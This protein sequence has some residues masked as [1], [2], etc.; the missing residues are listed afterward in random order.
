VGPEVELHDFPGGTM[1]WL[2]ETLG[3]LN[4]TAA[5]SQQQFFLMQHHPFHNRDSLDPFGHNVLFNFT[6]DDQQDKR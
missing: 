4:Q 6:F 3:A 5:S 2:R 1:D